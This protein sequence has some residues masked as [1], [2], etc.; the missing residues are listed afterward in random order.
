MKD[1][2]IIGILFPFLPLFLGF[3]LVFLQKTWGES[4][5]QLPIALMFVVIISCMISWLFSTIGLFL[6]KES[7]FDYYRTLFMILSIVY[8]L[9]AIILAL[10]I[11]WSLLFSLTIFLVGI[12]M[13][14]KTK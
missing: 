7:L 9:P 12:T 10:F 8:V 4:D 13:I 11:P 3:L 1:Q 2:K 6:F 14:I 5:S